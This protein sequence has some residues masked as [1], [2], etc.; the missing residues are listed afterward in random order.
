MEKFMLEYNCP[1]AFWGDPAIT[2][3]GGGIAITVSDKVIGGVGVS[4]LS[5]E[6]D[7]RIARLAIQHVYTKIG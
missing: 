4:G 6:E 5:E 1:P 3:F 2:G 7:E